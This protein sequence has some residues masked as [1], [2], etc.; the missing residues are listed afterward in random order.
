MPL[1]LYEGVQAVHLLCIYTLAFA[2]QLMKITENFSQ[3]I[4]NDL[5]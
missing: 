4:R 5:G 1:R 2:T 3:V